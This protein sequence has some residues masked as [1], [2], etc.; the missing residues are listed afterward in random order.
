M[1]PEVAVG[2]NAEHS[3]TTAE[4]AAREGAEAGAEIDGRSSTR[5]VAPHDFTQVPVVV[6]RQP[7]DLEIVYSRVLSHGV[8]NPGPPFR[9]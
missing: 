1:Y 4:G 9:S 8:E 7:H 3:R 5:V 6:Q 2:F